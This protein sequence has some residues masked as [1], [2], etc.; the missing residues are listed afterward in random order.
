[1][2]KRELVPL[3]FLSSWCLLIAVWLF[4]MVPR[5]CLLFVIVVFFGHMHLLFLSLIKAYKFNKGVPRHDDAAL[6]TRCYTS[7]FNLSTRG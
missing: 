1:M 7:K 2:G 6:L 3:L 5:V 4:L